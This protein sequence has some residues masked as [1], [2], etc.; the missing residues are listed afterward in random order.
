MGRISG[1]HLIVHFAWKERCQ[2]GNNT[3]IHV[4]VVVQLLSCVLLQYPMDCSTPGSSVHY[5]LDFG[6]VYVH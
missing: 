5:L 6:Q 3:L 1:S 4:A 2:K